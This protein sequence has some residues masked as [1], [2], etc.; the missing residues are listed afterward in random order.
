MNN[1]EYIKERFNQLPSVNDG[2]GLGV[3]R[4][5]AFDTLNKMGIPTTRHEEWKY[6]R[7]GSFFNKEYHYPE[8][9]AAAVT[10]ADLAP[11]RLPGYEQANELVYVNGRY[12]AE[13]S[14]VRSKGLTVQLLQEA[15][16]N[17]YQE[18]V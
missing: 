7:I 1:L 16:K 12:A 15:A 2:N 10:A 6:T 8:H 11:F 13:L 3:I 4:Q 14:V 18:I 5:K 9:K 17:E